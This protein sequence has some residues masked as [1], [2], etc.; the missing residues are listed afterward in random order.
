MFF[1]QPAYEASPQLLWQCVYLFAIGS[2][3]CRLW[4][5]LLMNMEW[6]RDTIGRPSLVKGRPWLLLPAVLGFLSSHPIVFI[7]I[8]VAVFS[9]AS[10]VMS[11]V[12]AL[13]ALV[14][15]GLS[16]FGALYAATSESMEPG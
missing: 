11:T 13:V 9:V 8:H 2:C 1:S 7:G 14:F 15:G 4:C 12:G 16:W 3:A 10:D 6:H 5:G